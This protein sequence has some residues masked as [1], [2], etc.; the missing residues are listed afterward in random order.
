MQKID[1]N[2][3]I[4]K[5][6]NHLVDH[7]SSSKEYKAR[8][9]ENA[10]WYFD[11]LREIC[12]KPEVRIV[13]EWGT[14]QGCSA[15]AMA[16]EDIDL[17]WTYDTHHNGNSA[18]AVI[19]KYIPSKLD[20]KWKI[21]D[22]RNGE[23]IDVDFTFLDNVHNGTWVHQE[24]HAHEAKVKHYIAVHDTLLQDRGMPRKLNSKEDIVWH[25]VTKFLKENKNWEVYK[26]VMA[27]SGIVV[28][29]RINE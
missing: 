2:G 18:R 22:T 11:V 27:G 4:F 6:L 26:H 19:E 7:V 3:K 20:F 21:G 10:T 5:D 13:T 12:A 23:E 17:L 9:S 24:L 28:L 14:F 29:K 8:T 15:A 1:L 16:T 25:G